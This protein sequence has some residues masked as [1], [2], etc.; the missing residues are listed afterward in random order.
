VEVRHLGPREFFTVR[1]IAELNR[2]WKES[3]G[4]AD[5]VIIVDMDEHIYHRD[6]REHLGWCTSEGITMLEPVGYDMISEDFPASSSTL[7]ESI[8]RGVRSFLLDKKA[9]FDP[10]AIE[11]VNYAPGRHASSPTG[12]LCFP[13]QREV[14]LLHYKHLGLDYLIPRTGALRGQRTEFELIQGWSLHY[15]RSAEEIRQDFEEMLRNA[16]DVIL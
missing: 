1:Q 15:F 16:E 6:L 5:W 11:D 2:C 13:E 10:N 14:R 12:R 8:R 7:C 9:I 3:R 4:H